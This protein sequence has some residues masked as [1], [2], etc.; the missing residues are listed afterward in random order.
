MKTWTIG[1]V[2]PDQG[3]KFPSVKPAN[4]RKKREVESLPCIQC[5][6]KFSDENSMKQHVL[7]MHIETKVKQSELK[8][9]DGMCNIC[10]QE[11]F[12]KKAMEW[13]EKECQGRTKEVKNNI[14]LTPGTLIKT[15]QIH[16][17]ACEICDENFTASSKWESIK[18]VNEHKN[19]A[20][21]VDMYQYRQNK[22][23][24]ECDFQADNEK[25]LKK[26]ARDCHDT[27][28]CTKSI[29]PPPKRK[30]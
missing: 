16:T 3:Q 19:K 20:H 13:H 23:C 12:A 9:T 28:D 27:W 11:I 10:G 8:N 14:V 26:H 2:K 6:E 30:K 21:P 25:N 22:D 5:K 1:K 24:D 15:A 7:Q 4:D 18:K 29:S 17:N